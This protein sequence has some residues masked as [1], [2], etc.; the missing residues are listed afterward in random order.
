MFV[1]VSTQQQLIIQHYYV[2]LCSIQGCLLLYELVNP[3]VV[4]VGMTDA[5]CPS[6]GCQ[7]PGP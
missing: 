1:L 2:Q 5:G 3:N 7:E 6:I 4:W